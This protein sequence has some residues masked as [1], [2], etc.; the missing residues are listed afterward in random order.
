MNK[1][2]ILEKHLE[3]KKTSVHSKPK[4]KDIENALRK[5]LNISR[6]P[7]SQFS[8]D[9]IV[10]FINGSNVA[11]RTMND[12]KS[13]IKV[14]IKWHFPDWSSRFR[15]L[16]RICKQ[17]KPQRSHEPEEMISYEDIEKIIKAENNLMWK[18]YFLV[19]FYGGFRISEAC[20]LLWSQVFF[21]P[22]GVIIKIHTS[23]TNKDFYKA[24]PPEAEQLLKELKK[25]S[26]SEFLFPSPFNKGES[27]HRHS[28]WDRLK[29]LSLK[30]IGRH[31]PPQI[32]RHSIAT[33]L[34]GDDKL[35]DDIVANQMGHTKDMRETY[36]NLNAE[37]I[38]DQA[39]ALW[40]KTKSMTPTEREELK[41]M[42]E[43]QGQRLKEFEENSISKKD[44]EKMILNALQKTAQRL[45]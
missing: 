14:L 2:T 31:I 17:Q 33:L 3:F 34:Y 29:P 40:I 20:R 27:I 32:F 36:K 10:K 30:A 1:D 42:I 19:L 18:N 39:R 13:Y 26:D 44:V 4:L 43:A 41:K 35:K 6:K 37:K 12:Y 16:D 28:V 5:F 25:N 24:L 22:K 11:I 7:F 8:E 21:E 38:K 9:E 45:K 23:K 15:N